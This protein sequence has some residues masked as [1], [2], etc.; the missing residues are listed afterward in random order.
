MKSTN[1]KF[2]FLFCACMI[3][4]ACGTKKENIVFDANNGGLFLPDGGAVS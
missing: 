1:N 3:F 2:V 4:I